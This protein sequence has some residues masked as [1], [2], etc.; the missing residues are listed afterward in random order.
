[1]YTV[2]AALAIMA[3][4]SAVRDAQAE[5]YITLYGMVDSGY[6]HQSYKYTRD[7]LDVRAYI[8]GVRDGVIGASRFGFNGSEDLGYGFSA[9][10]RLEQQFNLSTGM[11]P[12]GN[13]QFQRQAYVGLNSDEWGTLTLGRQYSVGAATTVAPNGWQLGKMNRVFGSTGVA[14][15]NRVDNSIKYATPNVAGLQAIMLYS[16]RDKGTM[17]RQTGISVGEHAS[18][19]STGLIY[20]NGDFD[21]GGSYDRRGA[22]SNWQINLSYDFKVFKFGLAY[23]QDRAG[24]IGWVGRSSSYIPAAHLPGRGSLDDRF[25]SH[26]YHIGLSAP[27]G[28]GLLYAG[29]N[30]S[31]S[32]MDDSDKWGDAAGNISTYQINYKYSLSK[33]TGLY[34]YG[35]YGKNLG[36]VK[37]LKGT[38]VGIGVQHKF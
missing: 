8:S 26:N 16:P 31:A 1:M 14:A 19:I 17:N 32:N 37:A 36:Y 30:Y 38:E 34:A 2:L 25:K 3:G 9:I 18:R 20:S 12:S 33:R 23:G 21:A 29:W 11:A 35:S 28:R 7:S 13:Y 5:T 24:K 22:T 4:F 6:G 10:F 27:I 15:G